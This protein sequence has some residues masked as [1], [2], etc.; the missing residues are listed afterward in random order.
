MNY[1]KRVE[2]PTASCGGGVEGG[3]CLMVTERYHISK[4]IATIMPSEIN[5]NFQPQI[6]PI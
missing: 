3:A 4:T 2:S 1:C 6:L 5:E